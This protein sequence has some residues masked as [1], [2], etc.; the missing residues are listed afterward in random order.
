[1]FRKK[2]GARVEAG[3]K[4]TFLRAKTAARQAM[5]DKFRAVQASQ[6]RGRFASSDIELK[7]HDVDLDDA[8]VTQAGALTASI[9]L[10]P[11][12]TTE[13]TRIGRKAV[14]KSINWRFDI[15]MNDTSSADTTSEVFRVIM[16]LDR[17]CNGAT[18]VVA[19]AAGILETDDYQSFNNLANKGRFLTLMDRT[20]DLNC[21]SGSGQNAAD[22]FGE[23]VMHDSLFKKVDIPIEFDAA[24]GAI[25]EIRSNNIGVVLIT[26]TGNLTTFAS[27][28]RL[29]FTD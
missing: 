15:T 11:Q 20:Y 1:M 16:Y 23:Q 5:V 17:Q 18:A 7:F 28:I 9:N 13:K 6:F 22:V 12:G 25:T 4:L 10:I 26:K 2:A 27:K 19:T 21:P 3:K 8:V 14:L 29:R 24:T